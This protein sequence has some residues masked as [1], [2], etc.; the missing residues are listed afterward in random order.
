LLVELLEPVIGSGGRLYLAKDSVL[1]SQTY[2]RSMGM[3]RIE[4]FLAV[5][6]TYDPEH[7]FQSDLFRR[8]FAQSSLLETS[9]LVERSIDSAYLKMVM[10]ILPPAE[11]IRNYFITL[12]QPFDRNTIHE[13]EQYLSQIQK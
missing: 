11:A 13:E 4:R 10:R 3:D 6:R 8:V 1:N 2:A 9:L 7:I 5:K 12:P